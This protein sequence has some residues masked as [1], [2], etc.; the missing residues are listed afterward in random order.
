M[1]LT[2]YGS[3]TLLRAASMWPPK[4]GM[5]NGNPQSTKFIPAKNLQEGADPRKI[6]ALKYLVQYGITKY[7]L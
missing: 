6:L 2:M 4:I 7:E 3:W 5:A 1:G